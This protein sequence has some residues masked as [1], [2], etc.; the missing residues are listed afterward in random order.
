MSSKTEVLTSLQE[1]GFT[2]EQAEEAWNSSGGKTL[3][4]ALNYLIAQQEGEVPAPEEDSVSSGATAGKAEGAEAQESEGT[5]AVAQ[6]LKC[7]ECGKQLRSNMDAEAHAARTGHASF[8]ESSES[9]KPLTEEERE[10]QLARLEEIRQAKR[11]QREEEEKARSKE[12]ELKRRET[13]KQASLAKHEREKQEAMLIAEERRRERKEQAIAKKRIKDEIA[14]DRADLKAADSAKDRTDLK[15]AD[16]AKKTASPEQAVGAEAPR[17]KKEY[18]ECKLNL[19]LPD[20]KS[21]PVSFKPEQLLNDVRLFVVTETAMLDFELGTTFPR[22]VFA[23][24]DYKKSL[25][26]L[27]LVPSAA[28][29]VSRSS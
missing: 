23:H 15:A 29:I 2:P 18:T 26:E 28:L 6:S 13:G 27:G 14:K 12:Q 20:G 7:D 22:K 3:E 10:Q 4:A 19:R 17:E 1:F 21:L 9:V 8:S 25:R 24:E 11:V 5:G 16:P